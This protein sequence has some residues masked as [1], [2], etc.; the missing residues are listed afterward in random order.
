MDSQEGSAGKLPQQRNLGPAGLSSSPSLPILLE[1]GEVTLLKSLANGSQ[2]SSNLGGN[3]FRHLASASKNA[4]LIAR[5][6]H[7]AV[8]QLCG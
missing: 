6:F 5:C 2:A 8:F 4:H 7:V 3:L 1:S